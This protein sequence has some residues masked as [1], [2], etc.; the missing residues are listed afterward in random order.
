MDILRFPGFRFICRRQCGA[1][2]SGTL[3]E[4]DGITTELLKKK[5]LPICGESQVEELLCR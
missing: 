5:G 2:F 4:G 3:T 1:L